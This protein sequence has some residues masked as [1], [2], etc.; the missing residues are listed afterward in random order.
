M[1]YAP[2]ALLLA[3][4]IHGSN[5]WEAGIYT[6]QT[7]TAVAIEPKDLECLSCRRPLIPECPDCAGDADPPTDD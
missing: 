3:G 1:R 2:L 5:R 4:C 7:S 6:Q